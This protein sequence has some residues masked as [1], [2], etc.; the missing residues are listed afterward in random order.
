[1]VTGNPTFEGYLG[2]VIVSTVGLD[3]TM[4]AS[5]FD[6]GFYRNPPGKDVSGAEEVL[7]DCSDRDAD[8]A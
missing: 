5:A 6:K 1:M 7:N 8:F 3:F 4:C 2:L